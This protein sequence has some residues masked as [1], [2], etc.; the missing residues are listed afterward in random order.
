MLQPGSDSRKAQSWEQSRSASLYRSLCDSAHAS[1]RSH[2]TDWLP[3]RRDG[4]DCSRGRL[5]LITSFPVIFRR[6]R[7]LGLFLREGRLRALIPAALVNF[8]AVSCNRSSNLAT[9]Y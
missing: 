7:V 8:P 5:S 1:T 6:S 4:G 2:P 3:W 9:F